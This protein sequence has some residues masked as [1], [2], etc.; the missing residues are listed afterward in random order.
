LTTM[1]DAYRPYASG[2]VTVAPA[3][4]STIAML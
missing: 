3:E 4:M 1:T 2:T